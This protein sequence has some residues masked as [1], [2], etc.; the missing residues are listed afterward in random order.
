VGNQSYSTGLALVAALTACSG[1]GAEE[2]A[3]AAESCVA[4][5]LV[6]QCPPGSDPIFE[7]SATSRC[8]GSGEFS[9]GG[10]GS[11]G[12]DLPTDPGTLPSGR[13]EGVCEGEGD[14]QVF[15][16]FRVPCEC[17]VE[18]I[19]DEGVFCK[20]CLDT[21]ACGNQVCEGTETPETCP[22]DCAC[23]C[24]PGGQRCN[25]DKLQ[26]CEQC[27]W[28]EL[29]CPSNEACRADAEEGASCQRVGI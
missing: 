23:V 6:A 22:E 9:G 11:S 24:E 29:A 26:I 3:A 28:T 8:E 27:R 15:C 2:A 20:D 18:R 16:R 1:E 4:S 17:G 13:V 12:T 25:G 19:T 21:A 7:A 10:G 5:D 14:C